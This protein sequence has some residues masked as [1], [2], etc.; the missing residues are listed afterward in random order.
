MNK[1]R[2]KDLEYSFLPEDYLKRA[3]HCLK[4]GKRDHMFYAAFE[5]RCGIEARL[6]EHISNMAN[7]AKHIKKGWQIAILGKE[8]ERVFSN[9]D[10]VSILI[11]ELD[12]GYEPL[13][14]LYTPVSRRL[15]EIGKRLGD[16]L[17]VQK[18]EHSIKDPWWK[19]MK[20]LLIEG[21]EHLLIAN[22]GTLLCP[23]LFN[24]VTLEGQFSARVT[25]KEGKR[26][27]LRLK[28][29]KIAK[30]NIRIEEL[31]F[32]EMLSIYQNQKRP[33]KSL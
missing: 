12:D 10:K 1:K 4:T 28:K 8:I 20:D 27:S 9:I 16:Y 7:V 30:N 3:F 19:E 11:I 17:H 25:I 32:Q 14:L 18:I 24:P 13:R 15:Q 29:G 6:R 2:Q 33:F 5:L 21:G 22:A 23:P 31:S 26:I